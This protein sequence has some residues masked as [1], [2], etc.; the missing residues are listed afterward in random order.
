MSFERSLC[1]RH[2][3][4]KHSGFG[5]ECTV[6]HRIFNRP[7]NHSGRCVGNELLLR[8]KATRTFTEEEAEEHRLFMRNLHQKIQDSKEDHRRTPSQRQQ[9]HQYNRKR[10]HQRN[11]RAEKENNNIEKRARSQE[12]ERVVRKEGT[13]KKESIPKEQTQPRPTA[14]QEQRQNDTKPQFTQQLETTNERAESNVEK[15]SK[16]KEDDCL[17][18]YAEGF[19][20]TEIQEAFNEIISTPQSS[21]ENISFPPVRKPATA[22]STPVLTSKISS[23]STSTSASSVY[24]PTSKESST[25]VPSYVPTPK[26]DDKLKKINESQK[27]RII[28]NVEGRKF[29]TAV[30]TLMAIPQSMLAKMISPGGVKSYS[31]DNVYTYFLDRNPHNFNYI[32][33]YLRN[34]G[35]LPLD[36]LPLDHKNLREICMEAK[37]YELRHLELICEKKIIEIKNL[38]LS[39][40]LAALSKI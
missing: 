23:I 11:F 20:D 14:L 36:A 12:T 22:P 30:S 5:Y 38:N 26:M 1:E 37:F 39:A 34:G 13:E 24:S 18:L 19:S 25:T 10:S 31:V 35:D 28:L 6:C 21:N 15:S 9:L 27:K 33:D 40:E 4:E 16:A 7:D 17:S 32:L 2:V 8:K 3:F 29:E